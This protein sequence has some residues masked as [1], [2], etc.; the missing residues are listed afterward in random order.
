METKIVKEFVMAH[1]APKFESLTGCNISMEDIAMTADGC[2]SI[3]PYESWA[4][5]HF[6]PEDPENFWFD[7]IDSWSY[8]FV[9]FDEI[10]E[11]MRWVAEQDYNWGAEYDEWAKAEYGED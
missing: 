8:R 6:D 11:L 9:D 4:G 1:I 3:H 2:I 5:W 7:N 10:V